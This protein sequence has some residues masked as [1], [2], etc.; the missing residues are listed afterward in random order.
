MNEWI[1]YRTLVGA[2]IRMNARGRTGRT[3]YGRALA[4]LTT[5][6][7]SAS[8][9]GISLAQYYDP[10]AYVY[11]S[12]AVTM[13]IVG[14][15]VM[16]TYAVILLDS[17]DDKLLAAYPIAQR[18]LFL[19]RATNLVLFVVLTVA[20]FAVPLAVIHYLAEGS[21]MS[22]LVFLC[23]E[24]AAAFWATGLFVVIYNLLMVASRRLTHIMSIAQVLLI[25]VLLFFYQ[26]LPSIT[27]HHTAV[28]VFLW[29][30]WVQIT[31]PIWF[32]QAHHA[33]MQF[34][35]AR[36]TVS[37]IFLL[38]GST[39]ALLLALRTRWMLLPV[40]DGNTRT[41]RR[42]TRH[43]RGSILQ[44]WLAERSPATAAGAALFGAL[45]L[46]ERSIR[47]QILPVVMMSVAVALYGVL[48]DELATPF[49]NGML[50][51]GARLHLPILVFYLSS[52]RHVEHVVMRAITPETVW[53]LE[54]QHGTALDFYAEG[55]ARAMFL[56]IIVPQ[57]L[58]LLLVF[59]TAMPPV[60]AVL[61]TM[62]LLVF[63][64]LQSTLL[65]LRRRIPPFTR[66]E[67]SFATMQRFAQFLV[68]IPFVTLAL[69]LHMGN[70]GTPTR[71]M[72]ML[73]VIALMS[74]VLRHATRLLRS[75][76][77]RRMMRPATALVLA[78][79]LHSCASQRAPEGGPPD[80]DPPVVYETVPAAGATRV[81]GDRVLLR[82]S[83]HVDRTSFAQALHVSPLQRIAPEIVWSGR[84]VELRFAEPFAPDRTY[85]I[86]VG[87]TVRDM[88][89]G[90]QMGASFLLAFSTGDSIDAGS[91]RGRVYDP[92]PAGVSLFA[93][94]LDTRAADTLDPT[95]VRPDYVV[96][97]GDDG[98]FTFA[99]LAAAPYRVIAVR[100]KQN[101]TMY[102]VQTD[103]FGTA[104]VDPVDVRDSTHLTLR[105][106]LATEDTTAPYTMALDAVCATRVL[107]TLS[108]V[109]ARDP[110]P[111]QLRMSDSA[112]GARIPLLAVLPVAGRR[113]M[114]ELHTAVTLDSHR[115]V[116]SADSVHDA[117]GNRWN[118][119]ASVHAFTG[120]R[121]PDTTRVRLVSTE[122][123]NRNT[124]I[125]PAQPV[126][127]R[128]SHPLRRLP[129]VTLSDSLGTLLP[130]SLEREDAATF[131]STGMLPEG[132]ALT[133]CIDLASCVDSLRGMPVADTLRCIQFRSAAADEFGSVSGSVEGL[134]S[135]DA[136]AVVRV[137]STA[138]NASP[139]STR[140]RAGGA[141]S[142]PRVQPGNYLLDAF[143]DR[144]STGVYAPGR[145]FP[146]S[147]SARFTV[148]TDTVRVR[149]RWE[150]ANIRLRIPPT[151]PA[152]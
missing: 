32:T 140:T 67:S 99:H 111:D 102:D 8:Y 70:R 92:K 68:V 50:S 39:L 64:N 4:F 85:V 69:L 118:A 126:I 62:F 24:A 35:N 98:S 58:V 38:G 114:Y 149:A 37:Q 19:A 27:G 127:L 20:P 71:F 78:F 40:D 120:S 75:L 107:W 15:T 65:G 77:L 73:V 31:P 9:L 104:Q 93:W 72:T 121:Q 44:R 22:S 150:N 81:A 89:A 143:I 1:V 46:R 53:I 109:P 146:F 138:P 144:D 7:I 94:R 59:L 63:G 28:T 123:A 14:F 54:Q 26:S 33:L 52:V 30:S 87:S 41:A 100:D 124:G 139:R 141:F 80:T 133:L 137:R 74:F 122:P 125:D 90:N 60:D 101:N 47:H 97:S 10:T 83:E 43:P 6:G 66:L 134:D 132:A 61:Q 42:T 152:D 11:L 21:L 116:L 147:P 12:L 145:P 17:G 91:V 16:S 56:R 115:Y 76:R 108:E 142:F 84:D 96:Q 113:G 117:A 135:S 151:V 18:T 88:N 148:G 36:M 13:Y 25:F 131:R 49:Q 136:P 57:L 55:V 5:Y 86:S 129:A 103:E 95:R 48:T 112:R 29:K 34:E 128:F 106:Q 82:F 130:I 105:Y 45:V 119:T 23:I 3:A 51:W 79:L 2:F 110:R